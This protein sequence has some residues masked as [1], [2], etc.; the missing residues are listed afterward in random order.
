MNGDGPDN[1]TLT[2]ESFRIEGRGTPNSLEEAEEKLYEAVQYPWRKC[3]LPSG[4]PAG[5]TASNIVRAGFLRFLVLEGDGR[6]FVHEKGVHLDGAFIEGNLDF[7][8]CEIK[9]PLFLTNC[10]FSGGLILEDA[11]T[12]TVKLDG[13][14]IPHIGAQRARIRGGLYLQHCKLLGQVRLIDADIAGSLECH[15]ADLAC[16][17]GPQVQAENNHIAL[18][19]S[20]AKIAGS[21]FLHQRCHVKGEVS[22]R[23]AII[24]GNLTCGSGRLSH[25]DG[26]ALDCDGAEVGGNVSMDKGFFAHGCVWFNGA[27]VRGKFLCD[28][29]VFRRGTGHESRALSAKRARL[30]GSVY[31]RK[32][33]GKH[34]S[35]H[36]GGFVAIGE[37]N[38]VDAKIG[39]SLECHG[40]QFL[41]AG[42]NA[43]YCSRAKVAGSASSSV[44]T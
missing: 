31:L 6:S 38:F 19:A 44:R 13:S 37:V 21:V 43:L 32:S 23:G 40:G 10:R 3:Q 42:G 30:D 9:R 2:L 29:G 28:G 16:A 33:D 26:N 20:R 1:Q 8:G 39:G 35:T 18:Y 11:L 7:H 15:G 12:C 36:R 24:R 22:F 5:R 17:T 41:N 4:L 25:P 27:R 34:P 14:V